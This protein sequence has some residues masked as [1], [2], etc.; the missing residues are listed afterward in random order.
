MRDPSDRAFP[1]VIPRID[2]FIATR[3]LFRRDETRARERE[4]RN[5]DDAA[6]YRRYGAS[7]SSSTVFFQLAPRAD[8]A[9]RRRAFTRGG[10]RDGLADTYLDTHRFIAK[11]NVDTHARDAAFIG[12]GATRVSP[13]FGRAR[14]RSFSVAV[15]LTAR[16]VK[17]AHVRPRSKNRPDLACRKSTSRRDTER[18]IVELCVSRRG[19]QFVL[20]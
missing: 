15:D 5:D 11:R 2:G 18:S 6:G 13:P 8:F 1:L 17:I 16:L 19:A 7:L 20:G 3:L 9:A 12:T 10:E 4:D 14:G